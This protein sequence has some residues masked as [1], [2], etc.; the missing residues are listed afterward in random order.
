VPGPSS[1]A[2]VLPANRYII[3]EPTSG[4]EPLTCSL[5]DIFG[6]RTID[7]VRLSSSRGAS[8]YSDTIYP[9]HD[10]GAYA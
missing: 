4:L 5:R 10:V 1:T 9:T 6:L 7:R 8:E 2:N 3:R